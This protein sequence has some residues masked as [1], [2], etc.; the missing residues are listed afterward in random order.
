MQKSEKIIKITIGGQQLGNNTAAAPILWQNIVILCTE[1]CAIIIYCRFLSAFHCQYIHK[2]LYLYLQLF[3]L[4]VQSFNE[5]MIR[6]PRR[7][8]QANHIQS[9]CVISPTN[10]P[11]PPQTQPWVISWL[12]GHRFQVELTIKLKRAVLTVH[13]D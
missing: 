11:R 8:Y 13:E 4:D 5:M 9:K 6:I 1:N 2:I 10:I 3:N 12:V 7:F